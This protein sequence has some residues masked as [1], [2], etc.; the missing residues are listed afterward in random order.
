VFNDPSDGASG[1]YSI[2]Q[3]YG[4]GKS[5]TEYSTLCA[6]LAEVASFLPFQNLLILRPQWVADILFAVVTRPQ[7][8]AHAVAAAVDSHSEWLRFELTALLSERLLA[9]LWSRFDESPELLIDVMINY[10]QMFEVSSPGSQVRQFL[11]PAMLPNTK[12]LVEDVDSG[13]IFR[14]NGLADDLHKM[15]ACFEGG[16]LSSSRAGSS[17]KS[18]GD[19]PV[20]DQKPA[21]YFVFEQAPKASATTANHPP[22]GSPLI[23]KGFI[24]EGFWFTLLVR[25][26]RWAQQTDHDWSQQH[27]AQSFRRDVARFS[28]GAQ[29]FELRLHRAQHAIR[30]VVL[31]DAINY[32]LG[33]LQRV[34]SLVDGTL[35]DHF[36][37]LQYF[38]ALRIETEG[39]SSLVD[40]A[41][42][43]SQVERRDF[44][45]SISVDASNSS[46]VVAVDGGDVAFMTCRPWCPP[47]DPDTEF[48]VYLS[49]V[50]ADKE[51]A[52]KVY[53]CFAKCSSASGN[54]IRVFL[55]NVSF[56]HSSRQITAEA[57]LH[58]STVFVPVIS[59]ASISVCGGMGNE[60]IALLVASRSEVA[61]EKFAIG[62]TVLTFIVNLITVFANHRG[63]DHP[64]DVELHQHVLGWY[65]ASVVVPRVFNIMFIT[66]TIL[67]EHRDHPRF[68]VW[69]HRNFQP[70]SVVAL[71]ACL[72]LDNFAL[73]QSSGIGRR[74]FASPPPIPSAV[75]N[76]SKAFGIVSTLFGDCLQLVISAKSL[77]HGNGWS[78]A[79]ATSLSQVIIS[80]ASLLHQLIIR[81]LA[82]L[83]VSAPHVE[84]QWLDHISETGQVLDCL[85]AEDL[86]RRQL[87][88]QSMP[89]KPSRD[90][91][92]L[93]SVLPLVVDPQC[94]DVHFSA[95]Q[96]SAKVMQQYTEVMGAAQFA[97]RTEEPPRIGALLTRLTQSVDATKLWIRGGAP[98]DSSDQ[99]DFAAR[100]VVQYLDR[101]G[102]SAS[103]G[104]GDGD[105]SE[106]R[107][108]R[109][110]RG[111]DRRSLG[112][113]LEM[114]GI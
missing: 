77:L 96:I 74:F 109:Q 25:C 45:S 100:A 14:L 92:K 91:S 2:A 16:P 41:T 94:L 79:D 64:Y 101:L 46:G 27:L 42:A 62:L 54:R 85:I 68:A 112:S 76:R 63:S 20:A 4:A 22:A 43:M 65:F 51:L 31:G 71:L 6:F 17:T 10:D 58:R 56:A 60:H 73:L 59:M 97:H 81:G 8:Q 82:F 50:D 11:V 21:C 34:R 7:F 53:D 107:R 38:V 37:A 28:F 15:G 95:E 108:Q 40:L 49:H 104:L 61:F 48:D 105:D 26:A 32:P 83:L 39:Q 3:Q 86:Q 80:T 52:S 113:E 90:R 19:W 29:Q 106:S 98:I 111:R 18:L 102:E 55:R 87:G 5:A 36:P 88:R 99:C 47:T 23:A 78:F 72:R 67:K 89:T 110:R 13:A 24:P 75:V 44:T 69:L 114:Q 103:T 66:R 1:L 70:F 93:A 30:L 33:V 35:A 12:D 84:Q 57:A 9:L